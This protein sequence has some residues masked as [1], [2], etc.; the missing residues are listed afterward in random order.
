MCVGFNWEGEAGGVRLGRWGE[1]GGGG[2]E[3]WSG[4]W[5]GGVLSRAVETG[6]VQWGGVVCCHLVSAGVGRDG[7]GWRELEWSG[8]DGGEAR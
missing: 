8:L 4:L 7:A 3:R 5:C 1:E 2:K 6:W